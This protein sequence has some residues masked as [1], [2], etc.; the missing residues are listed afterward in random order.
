MMRERFPPQLNL[1]FFGFGLPWIP[2]NLFG[3][4]FR[5]ANCC[6]N[7]D[8]ME[9]EISWPDPSGTHK[10]YS[11]GVYSKPPPESEP[12]NTHSV[13]NKET[14]SYTIYKSYSKITLKL[15]FNRKR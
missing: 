9:V 2:I 14:N 10:V 8:P 3:F 11:Q 4:G 7:K 13:F 5:S 6:P 1:S 12:P 15:D